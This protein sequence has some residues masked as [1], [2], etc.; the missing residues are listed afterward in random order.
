MTTTLRTLFFALAFWALAALPALAQRPQPPEIAARQYLLV[1]LTSG[2]VLAERDAD[3]QAEP[4]SL[5]KL[6]TAYLVFNA[7]RERKLALDQRVPVSTRAWNERRYGGSLMFIDPKMSPTVEELLHGMIVQSGN[8]A[9]VALAEAVSG[10]VEAFV[11][12]MNRQARAWGLKNTQFKNVTGLTEPGHYSSARDV[13]LMAARIV[14][15]HPQFHPLYSLRQYTF[16]NI[17]QDNR[18]L[19]LGRD[20]TVDGMKTGY[21]DAAGY[22]LVATAA[23]EMPNGKRRLLSVVLGTASREARAAESQKLLNWGWQAWDAIRLFEAGKPVV[24]VPVWKGRQS[25][26]GLGSAQ[27]IFVTVPRGEGDRLKTSI[28]RVDPLVAPL[29]QGQRVGTLKVSTAAGAQVAEVPLAVLEP[30]ELSGLLGRAWDAIR[31]W[32]Q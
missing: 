1:D 24:T 10:S 11:D 31:L 2:Q 16:N 19:L 29:V 8:D 17:R 14:Q 32:I 26:V 21:T 13:A 25:L 7:L 5:T 18:N 9:S 28:E 6:M 23:R 15:D 12:A 27:P 4:A 30:V 3:T 20:P 22:C